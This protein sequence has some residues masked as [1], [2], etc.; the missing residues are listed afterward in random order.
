MNKNYNK[1]VAIKVFFNVFKC[2]MNSNN[3]NIFVKDFG[4]I[5]VWF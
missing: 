5:C 4:H 3:I 2:F 1:I